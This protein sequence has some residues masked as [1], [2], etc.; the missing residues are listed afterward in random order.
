MDFTGRVP[1]LHMVYF[2]QAP[3][4]LYIMKSI[5]LL[6]HAPPFFKQNFLVFTLLSSWIYKLL[7]VYLPTSTFSFAP[8]STHWPTMENLHFTLLLPYYHHHHFH[9]KPRFHIWP[10][11]R[12]AC[13]VIIMTPNSIHFSPYSIID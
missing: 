5:C 4:P 11:K 2:E 9:N 1:W 13:V 10:H 6:Q 8:L 7:R 3:P 12:L